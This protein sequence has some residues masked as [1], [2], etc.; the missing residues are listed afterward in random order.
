MPTLRASHV[1]AGELF[2]SPTNA[3]LNFIF[4]LQHQFLNFSSEEFKRQLQDVADLIGCLLRP[5]RVT[6][7]CLQVGQQGG[8]V[9][10]SN[11]R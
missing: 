2:F 8:Q 4:T 6:S 11:F 5:H 7:W 3:Q 10:S 9:L 1:G